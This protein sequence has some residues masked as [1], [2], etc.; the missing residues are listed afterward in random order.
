MPM[1]DRKSSTDEY[2]Y[3]FQ[4]QLKDDELKGEGNSYD[5]GARMYDPRIGRWFKP[6]RLKTKFPDISAYVFSMDNPIIFIDYD[7]NDIIIFLKEYNNTTTH[8]HSQD[9]YRV[10]KQQSESMSYVILPSPGPDRI[11][12]ST[13]TKNHV[14]HVGDN[15][16]L[17]KD[18]HTTGSI[19]YIELQPFVNVGGYKAVNDRYCTTCKEGRAPVTSSSNGLFSIFD[20]DYVSI[21][22]IAPDDVKD[23]LI[24]NDHMY[25]ALYAYD[26]EYQITQIGL[27]IYSMAML[28]VDGGPAF[29]NLIKSSK[30]AVVLDDA[31][32]WADEGLEMIGGE[33][34]FK[35]APEIGFGAK[36]T[37]DG[38]TLELTEFAFYPKGASGNSMANGYDVGN[39]LGT[40]GKLK[41]YAKS[42]G[43]EKLRI[44][45]QRS[46]TS[47]SA[48]PGHTFD[49]TFDLTK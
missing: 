26:K 3:G 30:N 48:N 16:E 27:S 17:Y 31:F 45:F 14:I 7:G 18:E 34:T 32:I 8:F 22:K 29:L 12:Y 25:S 4:G 33:F 49:Q 1:P 21:A 20:G 24:E 6:D 42:Q 2:R 36:M 23:K 40:F 44:A 43:Y 37:K 41:E 9:Y 38:T 10:K 5:F 46:K 11:L 47:S 13:R 35:N 15:I 28:I 39:I 19:D